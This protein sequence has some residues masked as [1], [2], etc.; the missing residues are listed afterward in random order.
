MAEIGDLVPIDDNN[1]A[2]WPEGQAPSTVNDA[3][4]ADEGIMSRWHRDTN[5]SLASTGTS[6][7]YQLTTNQTLSAY[8]DGLEISFRAHVSCGVSPTL[9]LG[10]LGAANIVTPNQIEL[11]TDDIASGAKVNVIYDGSKWQLMNVTASSKIAFVDAANVFT[12]DQTI[13][14]ADSGAAAG[15]SLSLKR[16]SGSPAVSD[17]LAEIPFFGNN[18]SAAEITYAKVLAELRDPTAGSEDGRLLFQTNTGGTVATALAVEKGVFTP[19]ATGSDPGSDNINAKDYQIDGSSIKPQLAKAWANFSAT[20]GIVTVRD[21]L[22]VS[23]AR[24]S[25][26]VFTFTFS[27]AFAN[28]N[29]V[30]VA[31]VI[32]ELGNGGRWF[33]HL[34]NQAPTTTNYEIEVVDFNGARQDPEYLN[35]VFFGS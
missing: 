33:A 12:A 26:G 5:G 3:G 24:S 6:T 20:G 10:A 14:K 29:Y 2:R 13:E 22:N 7:A 1:T 21:S 11:T 30:A 18:D 35:I 19:G 8:Y 34:P 15:P 25:Q 9:Q 32:R 28:A 23:V 31:N 17:L 27:T 16:F 4:R